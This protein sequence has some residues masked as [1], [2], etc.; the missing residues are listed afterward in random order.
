M[1]PSFVRA[2]SLQADGGERIALVSAE[3]AGPVD[4][5][6]AG[7]GPAL[8]VLKTYRMMGHSSSDDPSKYRDEK[9]VEAWERRDPI[10]RFAKFLD[11]RGLMDTARRDAL[12]KEQLE[13]LDRVIHEQEAADPMPLRSLVED[14]Y[15]DVPMHLRR[16][17]NRFLEVAERFGDAQKGDGAFP[18]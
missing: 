15:A 14:V 1:G 16:Q 7:E 4:R 11:A 8:L 13:H 3:L 2:S 12:E 6:R 9:E 10:E 18:L 17:Y 5:A